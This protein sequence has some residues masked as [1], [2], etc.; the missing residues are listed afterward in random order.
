M[1]KFYN[2]TLFFVAFLML[3]TNVI[4]QKSHGFKSSDKSQSIEL[5]FYKNT[6]APITSKSIDY[7]VELKN[8]SKSSDVFRIEGNVFSCDD[9][10]A[11]DAPINFEI[12]DLNGSPLKKIKTSGNQPTKFIVR[13]TKLDQSD[14]SWGCVEIIATTDSSS[15]QSFATIMIKQLNPGAS[16]FK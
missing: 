10:E 7:F 16:N 5:S 3:Q 12:L 4:A 6:D 1:S 13:T 15:K 2:A 11:K 9:A 14:I 8:H